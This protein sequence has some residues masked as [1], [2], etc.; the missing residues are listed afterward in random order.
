MLF[1][2]LGDLFIESELKK[3][4]EKEIE[5]LRSY[6]E[7]QELR[8]KK[9]GLVSLNIE[10]AT[11]GITIAPMLLITFV[12]N[13]FKHGC[14]NRQPGIV[15]TLK[16]VDGDIR[17]EVCNYINRNKKTQEEKYGGIGL[18]NLKRRLEL[19]YNGKYSLDINE[20]NEQ[21]KVNLL[22]KN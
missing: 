9:P 13:A 17:F 18:S 2:T 16:M 6:I 10:G 1:C 20:D 19:I 11:K 21:F 8:F 4:F 22:I 15:I 12:E 3:F 5:Y 14:K 7:L